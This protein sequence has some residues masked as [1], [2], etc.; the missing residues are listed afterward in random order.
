MLRAPNLFLD[1]T[2]WGLR[3]EDD[4]QGGANWITLHAHRNAGMWTGRPRGKLLTSGRARGGS[5]LCQAVGGERTR[6][7]ARIP[8]GL[9]H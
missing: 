2:V 8:N 9:H 1:P 4:P 6:D 5:C 7:F 3:S